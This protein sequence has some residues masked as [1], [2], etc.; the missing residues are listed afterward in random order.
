[1]EHLSTIVG[2]EF[3]SGNLMSHQLILWALFGY[4]VAHLDCNLQ[5]RLTKFPMVGYLTLLL[6]CFFLFVAPY[7][8]SSAAAVESV[9]PKVPPTLGVLWIRA[10]VLFVFLVLWIKSRW[11]FAVATMAV[12]LTEQLVTIHYTYKLH[13][14]TDENERAKIAQFVRW[15]SLAA[16]IVMMV[17]VITGSTL[18]FYHAVLDTDMHLRD[19]YRLFTCHKRDT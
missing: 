7:Y 1:M 12:L 10:V 13:T 17:L 18:Y 2:N 5:V 16:G 3:I 8:A 14:I 6:C 19:V 4:V 9:A 15:I 11:E